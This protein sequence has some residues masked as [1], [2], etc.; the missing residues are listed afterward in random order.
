MATADRVLQVGTPAAIVAS[1]NRPEMLHET[2]HC[3]VRQTTPCQILISV[4]SARHVLPETLALPN[5]TGILGATGSCAQRNL[6]LSS[7]K[8]Q[9]KV[10]FCFDDDVEVEEHYVERMVEMFEAYPEVVLANGDNLGLGAAPGSL[11]R[12]RAKIL[13]SERL[14]AMTGEA[15]EAARTGLGSR[16][17]FRGD[18]LGKVV[19]DERLPLYGYQEDFDFSMECRHFG[20]IVTNRRCLMVH[21]ETAAGRTGAR[22]RGYS[23]IVNPIYIWSKGRGLSLGRP[24]AGAL[25]RTLKNA[26]R[27]RDAAGRQRLMGNVI[28]WTMILQ[29]KLLPEHILDMAD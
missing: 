25:K 4:P 16:M 9:P 13:I 27:C 8:T 11:T 10:V 26:R 22:R 29:G 6:A 23:E 12:E 20:Q 7:I 28:G 14:G 1:I 2:I 17:S 3:L 5:V 24:V 21:I 18:L 19:F 15:P